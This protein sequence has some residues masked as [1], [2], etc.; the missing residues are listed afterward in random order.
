M[1]KWGDRPHWEFDALFLG[2]DRH[3]DWLGIPVGTRAWFATVYT[4]DTGTGGSVTGNTTGSLSARV[5]TGV[6]VSG[7][8]GT[9]VTGNNLSFVHNVHT[10]SC[11][12]VDY[13]ADIRGGHASGTFSPTPLDTNLDGCL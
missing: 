4:S 9:T 11:P 2:S 12:A 7:M 1:S 8:L 5:V 10:G 3:G 13:A 6:A